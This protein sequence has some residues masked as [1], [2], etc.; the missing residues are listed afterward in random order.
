MKTT[1]GIYG[2]AIIMCILAGTRQ[3]NAATIITANPRQIGS[4]DPRTIGS[5]RIAMVAGV[6]QK[7]DVSEPYLSQVVCL[8]LLLFLSGDVPVCVEMT[9]WTLQDRCPDMP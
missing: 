7:V 3:T 6:Q 5:A 8:T 9:W 1:R 4:F 2:N